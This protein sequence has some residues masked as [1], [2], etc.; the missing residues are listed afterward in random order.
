MYD[1]QLAVSIAGLVNKLV[2]FAN[3][4]ELLSVISHSIFVIP[5]TLTDFTV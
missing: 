3:D 1:G 5:T 2:A 4:T